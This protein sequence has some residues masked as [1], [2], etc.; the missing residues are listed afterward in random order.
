MSTDMLD[1][2]VVVVTGA[3][4]GIGRAIALGAA[5]AGARVVVADHGLSLDGRDPSSEVAEAVV[6]EIA[7]L[8]GAAVG[9]AGT[10]TAMTDAERMVEAAVDAW[11]HV[12]GA[13]CCAGILR[14][15]PFLE[16]SEEDFDAVIATHLKGHFTVFKAAFAAMVRQGAGGA[17]VG[18]SSGYVSGDP[19]RASYRS[20]K[21]AV[22]ALTKSVA[23][24]GQEYGITA[25]C[26]S[27]VANTRMTEASGLR[28]ESEP[29][30]IAPMAVY[31]LSDAARD[32]V[33]RVFS[34]RGDTIATWREPEE[35]R[36]IRT[37]GGRWTPEEIAAQMVWLNG[38][39][40]L[41][42]LP[43]AVDR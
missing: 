24:A 26:I 38:G 22:I 2:K 17:L 43:T 4:R 8:G 37:T 36:L 27:P 6:A 31:L 21:A 28:F 13:V 5:A 15:R 41:P 1:E 11:G 7:A 16:L 35:E 12:D 25:N 19:I 40:P 10:V 39:A 9:V 18:I 3:G 42:E 32:L 30:D 14:H 20:A 23:L 29:A 33:G 34:A